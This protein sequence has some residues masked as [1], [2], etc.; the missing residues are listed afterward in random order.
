MHLLMGV[1]ILLVEILPAE[2]LFAKKSLAMSTIVQNVV[3]IMLFLAIL[4][5]VALKSGLMG[6]KLYL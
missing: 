5:H 4:L 1:F 6:R 2:L 3:F